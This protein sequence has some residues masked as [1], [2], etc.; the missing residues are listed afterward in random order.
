MES[1]VDPSA[2]FNT[3]PNAIE[4]LKGEMKTFLFCSTVF[5]CEKSF[6][7]KELS[8]ETTDFSNTVRFPMIG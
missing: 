6:N 1:S 2:P 3:I 4:T 7:P 8:D 5:K